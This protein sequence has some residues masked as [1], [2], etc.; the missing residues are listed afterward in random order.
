MAT[1]KQ[2]QAA[3]VVETVEAIETA[4]PEG[5]ETVEQAPGQYVVAWHIKANGQRFAPGD[6]VDLDE[7]TAAPFLAS[8][9]IAKA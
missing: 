7:A 6:V 4:Q 3:E 8:G 2:A 1:K 5:V 9:A